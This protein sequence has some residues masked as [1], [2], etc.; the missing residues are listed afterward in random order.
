MEQIF[1]GDF[2]GWRVGLTFAY[3]VQNREAKARRNIAGLNLE[4][5]E[6][7]IEDLKNT[8]ITEVRR[9]V[10]AVETAAK[11]IDSAKVS[12]RLQ[13]KNL[14]AEKKRYENG[15]S[16]SYRVLEIQEDLT[17]AASRL[18]T[19]IA[20]YNRATAEYYRSIGRLLQE[21]NVKFLEEMDG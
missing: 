21:N 8:V 16:T 19:A 12:R 2:D 6:A 18:V 5:G 7:E 11:Q 20:T 14:E 1:N 17:R 10:R 9:A 13:E 15:L 4:K 3:P